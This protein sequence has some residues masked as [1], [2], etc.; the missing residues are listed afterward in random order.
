ML[1]SNDLAVLGVS[2]TDGGTPSGPRISRGARGRESGEG[3]ERDTINRLGSRDSR[4]LREGIVVVL[5]LVAVL[6]PGRS[7]SS[8][9]TVSE[10]VDR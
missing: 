1:L 2:L 7:C 4:C 8:R 3:G 5:P 9:E 10:S 6:G